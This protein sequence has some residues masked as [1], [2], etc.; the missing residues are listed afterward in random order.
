MSCLVLAAF[1]SGMACA[2]STGG[3]AAWGENNAYQCDVPAPNADFVMVECGD[4]HSLGLKLDSVIVAWGSNGEHQCDVP[5]PN[6]GFIAVAG[7][8]YHSLGLKADGTVAAWG[9][10]YFYQCDVPAPNADFAAISAGKIFSMGLKS[11]S[12]VVVWGDNFYGQRSV[13]A[14]NADFIAIAAGGT[15]CLG[16]K[17][18]STIVGWGQN[19][20]GQCNV[21]AP[22]EDFVAI[23]AGDGFSLGVKSDGTIVAFGYNN[24]GQCNVPE[25]NSDFVAAAGGAFHSLGL[26][27]DGSIVA[28]GSNIEGQCNVPEPNEGYLAISA[29]AKFCLALA[30]NPIC[31]VSPTSIEF[32]SV[33]ID[34]YKDTTFVIVNAG[35]GT[36]TGSVSEACAYFNII[37]GEGSYD[38]YSGESLYVTVRFEPQT[39]DAVACTISAGG[40]CTDVICTGTGNRMPRIHAVRDVPGDQGGF[41]N[42]AWDAVPGD[43]PSEHVI[44]RYTVWRAINPTALELSS[45]DPGFIIK[46][47]S[48]LPAS[49]L[50]GTVRMMHA[51]G[52]TYYWKLISS[53]D[54]YYLEAYSEVVPTL[55]D[56]TE[57]CV[58]YH[59]L[60]IIAHTSDPYTFWISPPD[61]GRSVDNLAPAAPLGLAGAAVTGPP[62]LELTWDPNFEADLSHY[63]VYR[64]GDEAFVPG[65]GNLVGTAPDTVLTDEYAGWPTS[66]YKV[67]AVDVHGNESPFALLSPEDVAGDET[68]ETPAVNFLA[69]NFPNPFNPVTTI[70]FGLKAPAH[71]SLRVYDAAG[72]IV[73]VL[74]DEPRPA[75]RYEAAWDG[76]GRAGRQIA[77]GIYF[78]RIEAGEYAEMKKMVLLR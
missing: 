27:S 9:Y 65:P 67:S 14:P 43:N 21:P 46:R 22:N 76:R 77:S 13:P 74:V 48:D 26:K 52:L 42:V 71:V 45:V 29:D 30:D 25:P 18:D 20:H 68:P 37:S 62:A 38:I 66:Y 59:Y 16:L 5:A 54:A 19:N 10:N 32:G 11:D 55:F 8:Q 61:S 70:R 78:Y 12:T 34:E 53:L 72:R 73:R 50:P 56:S 64:G 15:H 51:G 63:A 6:S 69:Q 33:T 2:Q 28:W 47:I 7:G 49:A 44:T 60:Q 41:I 4:Y 23:A 40:S 35:Y 3:I 1:V 31:D 17:S 24:Y 58:E 75:G 36:L 39:T 57:A